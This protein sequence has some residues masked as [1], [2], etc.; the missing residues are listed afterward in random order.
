MDI[1]EETK[2]S[3]DKLST[4]DKIPIPTAFRKSQFKA[5]PPVSSKG[6]NTSNAK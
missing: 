1:K 2:G 5:P 6:S 4:Q 3:S